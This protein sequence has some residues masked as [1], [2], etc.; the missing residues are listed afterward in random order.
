MIDLYILYATMSAVVTS[1]IMTVY[2]VTKKFKEFEK[3]MSKC[4]KINK[5]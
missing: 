3:R 2:W 5:K 4:N 1:E